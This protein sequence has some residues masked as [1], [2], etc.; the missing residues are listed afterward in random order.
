MN[1]IDLIKLWLR[2]F[3]L[4]SLSIL[5]GALACVVFISFIKI[6]INVDISLQG[7]NHIFME[8]LKHLIDEYL[9]I[10][11]SI[12]VLLGAVGATKVFVERK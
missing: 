4:I 10:P 3:I 2:A 8:I 5:L 9:Y 6:Y 7:K 12:S 1:K 11:L